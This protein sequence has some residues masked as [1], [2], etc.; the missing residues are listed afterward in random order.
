M[1]TLW[2]GGKIRTLQTESELFDAVFVENGEVVE[3]GTYDY[4]INNKQID[5]S[6][7]INLSGS[8]MYPGFVDS[9]LHMI[10]HGEKLLK[11]DVSEITSIRNLKQILLEAT[12]D[13][14][15]GE[16]LLAEGFN[17]NLYPE[18]TVPDRKILDSVSTKH[19]IMITRVCRHALTTNT[20]GLNLAKIDAKV[21]DPPGGIIVRDEKG[22]PTG[23]LHDQAQ[24]LLKNILPVEGFAYI[25]R[26]LETS[27]EDLYKNG[28]VG[29]HSEDL[30]YYGSAEKTLETFYQVIDGE[31]R[32]F[33]AN[34]LVHHEVVD[35]VIKYRDKQSNPETFIEIGAVKIFADG[36]LGGR[37]ALLSEP[38]SDDPE[39]Q[40]VAIHSKE[41]LAE[42]V[43]KARDLAMP[44]AIHT[45]GDL[46]LDYAISAIEDS[47][48]PRGKRDRLIHL[49][50][51]RQD[52]LDRLKVLPVVLDIQPRFV[53]SD[54]PWVES[55]LGAARLVYSFAWKTML[56]N[57][58][59][60]AL[61]SDAPIEPV[62]PL[63]G[64][65]AAV[66]RRKPEEN[67][68][69]YN[70]KEKLS[71]Y[72]A[73]QLVTRGSAQAICKEDDRGI[74]APGYLADF[75]VLSED[76]FDLTPDQWLQVKV[77]KTI[78]DNTIMYDRKKS[79]VHF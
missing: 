59:I 8:V 17:E 25:K 41:G 74:I 36:A 57:E 44:V 32:K 14:N 13:L 66:T 53:A 46:A 77:D 64:I 67:H 55:R 54:F 51:A 12:K 22:D 24:E 49:Q 43:K 78:V 40:G 31:S 68:E 27:L 75:T 48:V 61:G 6:K 70:K 72:E 16:W 62:N 21:T 29:A 10:G 4:F 7:E 26:A 38:Y 1:G 79:K 63:L 11:L 58:L 19:P 39:T 30:N 20:Y 23:Y 33:R 9:H 5:I 69:G 50:V 60:C 73:L 71:L 15:D 37:T 56:N 18:K 65:H 3:L 47:P 52:L 42:V 45:I 76:L 28:Y 2:Y 34:L 35:E